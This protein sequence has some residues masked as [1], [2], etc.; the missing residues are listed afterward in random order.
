MYATGLFAVALSWRAHALHFI[1][2][3]QLFGCDH[4][5]QQR[6]ISVA[7]RGSSDQFSYRAAHF[8]RADVRQKIFGSAADAFLFGYGCAV[9]E[10]IADWFRSQQTFVDESSDQRFDGGLFPIHFFLQ[11]RN[12][13]PACRFPVCPDN[14]H[15]F[16]FSVGYL[17]LCRIGHF[18]HPSVVDLC[19]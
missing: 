18:V 1:D 8:F 17:F 4:L 5:F 3:G 15:D 2:S 9:D 11:D 7:Q 14:T 12:D 10:F 13:F 19:F 6:N 16:P